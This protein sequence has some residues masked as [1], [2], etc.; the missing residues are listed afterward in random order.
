MSTTAPGNETTPSRTNW[1][2]WMVE[3]QT[4]SRIETAISRL[5]PLPMPRSVICSPSHMTNTAPAVSVV[6]MI[7]R[8]ENPGT[9]TA[10]GMLSV[11]R[12]KV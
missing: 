5:M 10:P 1:I 4:R 3:G 2:S 11:N 9:G 6:T 8:D 7:S 12:V